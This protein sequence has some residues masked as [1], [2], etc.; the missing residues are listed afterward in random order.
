MNVTVLGLWHLGTVT[1]ACVAR[2]HQV[3][4]LDFDDSVVAGLL[5]GKAP[6]HE[7]GL[8]ALLNAG[9]ASGRLEFTTDAGSVAETEVLWVCYD[10]PVNADDQSDTAWVL[11]QV[12]RVLPRLRDGTVVLLSS[13]LP[14]GTCDQLARN[15]PRLH[16]A[17]SPEN[18]RLGS[19]INAFE[20]AARIVIGVASVPA[21]EVLEEL[22]KPFGIPLVWVRPASAEMV[23]HALN[24]FL[25]LSV[26][27]IN[28]IA[29]LCETVGADAHRQLA[30]QVHIFGRDLSLYQRPF[31]P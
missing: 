18:L 17:C 10:T 6:L 8:E 22:L 25:A 3:T 26:T 31:S 24:S 23:K 5:A 14:V 11:Q 9:L 15:H 16:L 4:V 29:T 20:R 7:P 19:A 30:L 27:F 13:Q 1:A 28:E 2:H 12:D 21:R